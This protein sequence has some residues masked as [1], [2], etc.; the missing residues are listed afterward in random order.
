MVH[1]LSAERSPGLGESDS[2]PLALLDERTFGTP[3]THDREKDVAIADPDPALPTYEGLDEWVEGEYVTRHVSVPQAGIDYDQHMIDGFEVDPTTVVVT[4]TDTAPESAARP[5][6][7]H[8]AESLEVWEVIHS[9]WKK[10]GT[11]IREG[12]RDGT[13]VC[14]PPDLDCLL[15][16]PK[17]LGYDPMDYLTGWC[18]TAIACL[19]GG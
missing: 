16:R 17:L 4:M 3:R 11:I 1:G 2:L 14:T 12:S 8:G 15:N 5:P 7:P 13:I 18:N 10:L 6:L 19:A 9:P